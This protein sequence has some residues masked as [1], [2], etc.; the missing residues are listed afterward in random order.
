[1]TPAPVVGQAFS[2][3]DEALDLNGSA[4]SP[5]L[6]EAVVRL[7]NWLPFEQ[8]PEQLAFLTGVT[9]S[10]ETVRRL[11]EAAG[12]ALVAVE[13]AAL[14]KQER[15]RPEGPTG[16]ARQQVSADGAMVPLMHGAWAEVKT[17]VVGTVEGRTT[18]SGDSVLHT[19]DL[20]S[21][22]RLADA[23]QF[24]QVAWGE[25]Q[26]RGTPTAGVVVGVMDGA[27]WLQGFLD[28]QRPDAV[29]ILDFPHAVE[30]LSQ[31]VQGSLGVGSAATTAWLAEQAH[32]LK[33][34][35]PALVPAAVAA[36]PSEGA[37]D[38]VAA[39]QAQDQTLAYLAKRWEQ[40]QYATFQRQG[41]PIGSGAVESANKLVVEARLKGS[42]MP[43][44]R[45]NVN[46]MVALRAMACSDRWQGEW[47][48]IVAEQRRQ[49]RERRRQRCEARRSARLV[50]PGSASPALSFCPP[51]AEP[52][53]AAVAAA[54]PPTIVNGRPTNRH[55]W[56]RFPLL[57]RQRS[58]IVES[59]KT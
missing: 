59:A 35:D 20:S 27:E 45:P 52:S 22:S 7:G 54:P 24:G 57:H 33:H 50:V 34:G 16:P 5:W 48:Q 46:P 51:I 40:I 58:R 44:A 31:A 43:W 38:P 39:A 11:T 1:M 23:E 41:Y 30:H 19:T 47:P 12:S 15:E 49:G 29:R 9:L 13:T 25:L 10:V 42:G 21:C 56:K 55:P 6:Q 2:P 3:L 14:S 53:T 32:V 4:L 17:L 26:R 36:L 37:V 28:V 8:V 18:A